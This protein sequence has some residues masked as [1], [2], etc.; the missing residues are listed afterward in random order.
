MF[1]G[2]MM[3][4]QVRL[5]LNTYWFPLLFPLIS[6]LFV[7]VQF[8]I[9]ILLSLHSLKIELRWNSIESGKEKSIQFV[10]CEP[11]DQ[12][13]AFLASTQ[14]P[15]SSFQVVLLFRAV[16]VSDFVYFSG[17]KQW[18]S[19]LVSLSHRMI[20]HETRGM[21]YGQHAQRNHPNAVTYRCFLLE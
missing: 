21:T 7:S 20:C 5:F 10:L 12:V 13:F 8:L 11:R 16:S 19:V 3:E 1:G 17:E 9:C 6:V 18:N 4:L 2:L 15:S 14:F